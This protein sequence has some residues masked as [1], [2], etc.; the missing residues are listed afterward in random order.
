MLACNILSHL[1]IECL[2]IITY[3]SKPE[4]LRVLAC[5]I[6]NTPLYM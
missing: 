5:N 3:T 4:M 6:G 2:F 1:F